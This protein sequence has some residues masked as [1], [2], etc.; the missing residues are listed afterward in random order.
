AR[1]QE[2]HEHDRGQRPPN[3]FCAHRPRVRLRRHG[4]VVG[5]PPV[6]GRTSNPD[7]LTLF[8]VCWALAHWSHL[9]EDI[10]LRASAGHLPEASHL[11]VSLGIGWVLLRPSRSQRLVP[12]AVA[13]LWS[14]WN[15]VPNA[16]NHWLL[17][18]LVDLAIVIAFIWSRLSKG[19]RSFGELVV[20]A[21][22]WT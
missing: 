1:T 4:C 3:Q 22:Q 17:V 10:G 12:L 20:P 2:G 7:K 11:M 6:T 13:G 18:G 9:M 5:S 8:A 19:Q 16:P 14:V 15:E 21:A